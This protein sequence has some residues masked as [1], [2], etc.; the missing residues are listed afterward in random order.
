M[1]DSKVKVLFYIACILLIIFIFGFIFKTNKSYK[2]YKVGNHLGLRLKYSLKIINNDK[3]NDADISLIIPQIPTIIPFQKAK[4]IYCSHKPAKTYLENDNIMLS[5]RFK[6]PKKEELKLTFEYL[7]DTYDVDFEV[8]PADVVID[9]F[10]KFTGFEPYIEST[11]SK[12]TEK[13]KIINESEYNPYYQILNIYDYISKKYKFD[14]TLKPKSALEALNSDVLQCSDSTLLYAALVRSLK[15]PVRIFGGI[16]YWNE[17]N[18]N[19]RETHAWCE[20]YMGKKNGWITADP[21]L[22]RFDEF[23]R[24]KNFAHNTNKHIYLW[25]DMLQ[26]YIV[27]F[28]NKIDPSGIQTDLNFEIEKTTS[29]KAKPSQKEIFEI[30]KSNYGE[31]LTRTEKQSFE[32]ALGFLESEDCAAALG[33]FN[34]LISRRPDFLPAHE[35][36]ILS[37]YYL[38]RIKEYISNNYSFCMGKVDNNKFLFLTGTALI[39]DF[40]YSLAES[41]LN[42]ALN[43]DFS[44]KSYV[45]SSLGTLYER[46]KQVSKA[47]EYYKKSLELN[48]GNLF[49]RINLFKLYFNQHDWRTIVNYAEKDE[50]YYKKQYFFPLLIGCAYLN[51]KMYDKAISYL[52][53]S[54]GN[55]PDLGTPHILL[56]LAY[57]E[58]K[59]YKKAEKEIEKGIK[60]RKGLGDVEFFKQ[61]LENLD[62]ST[63][64]S[65]TGIKVNNK[66][67]D[68]NK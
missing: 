13:A 16:Y 23:S 52:T 46:T 22:G 32:K 60:L 12:I 8:N 15:I 41:C 44:D 2:N 21:T 49:A 26:P 58:L 35:G 48:P 66:E 36:Q 24:A 47:L 68:I 29:K 33:C 53:I 18:K 9:D 27:C 64:D 38:G 54:C 63:A 11:N 28:N 67:N 57:K 50:K 31:A 39:Y 10:K 61:I 5:Y 3:I 14:L 51:C 30:K 37:Y 20:V 34:N 4:L 19:Y 17:N 7:I 43:S 65:N 59:E 42:K 45:L 40:K 55:A 56:G 62:K 6:I 1:K 25:R